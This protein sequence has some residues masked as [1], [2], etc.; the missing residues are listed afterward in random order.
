MN[1]RNTLLRLVRLTHEVVF[2]CNTSHNLHFVYSRITLLDI[3]KKKVKNA[4]WT[5]L[6]KSIQWRYGSVGLLGS[7][8]NLV[9]RSI[10]A[11]CI[12]SPIPVLDS[13]SDIKSTKRYPHSALVP[14]LNTQQNK[15]L[16]ERFYPFSKVSS[17]PQDVGT[18]HSKSECVNSGLLV[19]INVFC[20]GP[21]IRR[22]TLLVALDMHLTALWEVV[23]WR[24]LVHARV[25]Q[26]RLKRA[27]IEGL[28]AKVSTAAWYWDR[29]WETRNMS[30]DFLQ[31]VKWIAIWFCKDY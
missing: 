11:M 23:N 12:I 14:L 21:A 9:P 27:W 8:S 4:Q 16:S 3:I 28:W 31:K 13:F 5:F 25:G 17:P 10:P 7:A 30:E 22:T 1:P 24:I 15:P 20:M 6:S 19:S 18:I 29:W 2:T 26:A